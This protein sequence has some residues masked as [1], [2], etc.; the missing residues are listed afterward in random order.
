MGKLLMINLKGLVNMN[1]NT[2]YLIDGL[3]KSEYSI[4]ECKIKNHSSDWRKNFNGKADL[5]IF[6]KSIRSLKKIIKRC[7]EKKISIIP[8]G[9]N[10][11]LVGGS[12]PL[13]KSSRNQVIVNLKNFNKILD[14]DPQSL[15]IHIQ[16]GC[17][18]EDIQNFLL[19][20]GFKFPL[21]IGSK[22]NCQ[23]GGNISTN[24][25]GVNVVKYGSLRSNVIGLE[26]IMGNGILFSDIK[27]IRKDN[28][29]YDLK[30]LLIGSEGTLGIITSAS[31]RIYPM[32]KET[33]VIFG[34]FKTIRELI[35]FYSKIRINFHDLI[36][37]FEL[38]NNDAMELVI[39]YKQKKRLLD[40]N[41]FYCLIEL[42]NFFKETKIFNAIENFFFKNLTNPNCFIFS[43][44]YEE[45]KKIW[46]YR[47]LIPLAETVIGCCINHDISI[48]LNKMENFLKKTEEEISKI[49]K[50]F[51]IINF[52]HV[53]DNNLHY[54]IY[55][56]NKFKNPKLKKNENLVNS[57]IFENAYRN[58]GSF[59]AEHGIGQLRVNEL[60][61]YKS[62][63]EFTKMKKIKKLFDPNNILNPNKLFKI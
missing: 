35:N 26:A 13:K 1:K 61:K 38:I 20:S 42:S 49:D 53:G 5:I 14:L 55:S 51:A 32:P 19:K 48:P 9:G 6:P 39:K 57:I 59:S 34:T 21:S 11:G 22:G 27:N 12:V 46:E 7:N 4:D 40:Q 37:S 45:N 47:D 43:K 33:R 25:G 50:D 29:G 10:T 30:Q 15:S 63:F 8:Q 23:I 36:T 28:S 44:S 31:L 16:S 17:I 58:G 3:K 56:R 2:Q 41:N 18:L 62:N 52:G 60:R 54:N 24:A